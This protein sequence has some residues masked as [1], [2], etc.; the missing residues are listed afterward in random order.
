MA[1]TLSPKHLLHI[2]KIVLNKIRIATRKRLPKH[3]IDNLRCSSYLDWLSEDVV[4][5]LSTYIAGLKDNNEHVIAQVEKP[6]DWL[7]AFRLRFFPRL[8]IGKW[9]IKMEVIN[10]SMS[11]NSTYIFPDIICPENDN[12]RNFLVAYSKEHGID[13]ERRDYTHGSTREDFYGEDARR[14]AGRPL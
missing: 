2:E 6:V 12:I 3:M 9:P 13:S 11:S 4:V 10:T 7:D 1:T 14:K 5:E 8:L